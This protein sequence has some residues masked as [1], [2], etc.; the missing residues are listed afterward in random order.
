MAYVKP[1]ISQH[2]FHVK[3]AVP[4]LNHT[5]HGAFQMAGLIIQDGL[6]L[7]ALIAIVRFTTGA[8]GR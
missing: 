3:T 2:L 7:Y 4:T 8:R 1:V 5:I 6:V